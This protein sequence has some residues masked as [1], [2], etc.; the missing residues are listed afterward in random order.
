MTVKKAVWGVIGGQE[1]DPREPRDRR[2]RDLEQPQS[3]LL[4]VDYQSEPSLAGSEPPLFLERGVPSHWLSIYPLLKFGLKY[5]LLLNFIL[6][7]Q[8]ALDSEPR[9][10]KYDFLFFR[11]HFSF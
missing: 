9:V 5:Q 11:T 4:N 10:G 2:R 7:L 8:V 1:A 6:N 3:F